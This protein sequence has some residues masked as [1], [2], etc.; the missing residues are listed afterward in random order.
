MPPADPGRRLISPTQAL[1]ISQVPA[2]IWNLE[3]KDQSVPGAGQTEWANRKLGGGGPAGPGIKDS[4]GSRRGWL[5]AYRSPGS[6]PRFPTIVHCARPAGERRGGRRSHAG[7]EQQE[8][9]AVPGRCAGRTP[10]APPPDSPLSASVL[11][12][13]LPAPGDL[14]S[15][16]KRTRGAQSRLGSCL[17]KV[18]SGPRLG[19]KPVVFPNKS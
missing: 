13:S 15:L 2:G 1:P 5:Q 10:P 14:P 11:H 16:S 7:Q 12:P 4:G 8:A 3:F 19:E 18:L 17:G 6:G 9:P